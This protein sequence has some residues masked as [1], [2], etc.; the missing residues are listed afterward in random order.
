MAES[1]PHLSLER[2][3]PI[4]EKRLGRGPRFEAPEDPS[5][6]ASGL[7]YRLF[8]ARE[9]T[10]EDEG[11]F[12]ERLLFR[13]TVDKAFDPELLQRISPEIE[14]VSQEDKEVVVAFVSSAA[15]ESF[16][17]RLASMIKGERV[18]YKHVLYALKSIDTWSRE[19]REGWALKKEGFPQ[20]SPFLLDVELWPLEDREDAQKRLWEAFD[21]WLEQN[22]IERLDSVRQP[23]LSLCR[24]RC[25]HAQAEKLLRHRDI[26]TVDLPPRFGLDR[27]ILKADIQEL[28]PPPSPPEKSPG[29]VILDSGL[30]TGHPLLASAVGD[31]QSFLPGKDENDEHGH[32][33]QVAGL[34]L[35]GDVDACWQRRAFVPSL[36]LFSGRILD[37]SN[38]NDSGFVENHIDG[39]VRYF[40]EEYGCKVF[41][42]S[43]GD[44]NKPYVGGHIR[45]LAYTLDTLSRELGVLFVVSAGNV[46][47][48]QLEGLEWRE[49]YPEYLNEEDWVIIDPATA[50]NALTVGSLARYDQTFASQRWIKDPAQVPLARREQPS[51][52]TRHGPSV[53][54]AIKPELMAFGGNWAINTRAGANIIAPCRGLG[55]VSTSKDYIEGRLFTEESGTSMAV[56]HVAHLAASLL[57]EHPNADSNLIRAL[58]VGHA[59]VPEASQHTFDDYGSLRNVCGYGCVDTK[60]LFR[61][62]ENEVTMTASAQIANKQHHFYEIPIPDE[63]TSNGRRPREISVALAYTP[64]VRSTRIAYKA[65]RIDFK[66]VSAQNLD[67]VTTMF[68]V[69]TK[70]DDYERISEGNT[71]RDVSSTVRNGGTVQATT[72]RYSQ[73]SKNANLRNNRLFVVVTRNDHPWGEVHSATNEAYSLVVC[74]RDRENEKARLYT[75]LRNRLQARARARI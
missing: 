16:E 6:H 4:T 11:G 14:F 38:V 8:S 28:P 63:F 55:E 23:G 56:P 49:R 1:F 29:I 31:A 10:A 64:Y 41:N 74:M 50:L 40:H 43:F 15:L 17:A 27:A 44:G 75:V 53:G 68:N 19:N 58:L 69:A 34:A 46:F 2:E 59:S 71:N 26:R 24:L 7:H 18:K 48:S 70:K 36:R 47:G 62:L 42:L 3:S 5:A 39:A 66:V 52:F 9:Q 73:F 54:G 37:E 45:G 51:P 67:Y 35:Y 21:R 60:A 61:S 13:F 22:G 12:D 57:R 20:D 72:W 25:D 32:G 33:T 65:T 30:T